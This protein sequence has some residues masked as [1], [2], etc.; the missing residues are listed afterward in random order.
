LGLLRLQ[1]A[2][3]QPLALTS[4]SLLVVVQAAVNQMVQ[5]VVVLV[6]TEHLLGL[7]E[8]VQQPNQP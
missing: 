6:V 3:P 7:V 5:A 8:A 1:I 4:W 2:Y